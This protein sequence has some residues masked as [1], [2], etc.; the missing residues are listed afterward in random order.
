M[1]W[2][3]PVWRAVTPPIDGPEAAGYGRR[4]DDPRA[5]VDGDARPLGASRAPTYCAIDA[6]VAEGGAQAEQGTRND[7]LCAHTCS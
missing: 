4:P 6:A 2:L 3:V 5:F 7:S 1:H